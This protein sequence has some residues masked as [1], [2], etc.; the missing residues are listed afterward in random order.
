MNT[1]TVDNFEVE[2]GESH[3]V[4]TALRNGSGGKISR[5]GKLT[6]KPGARVPAEGLTS[7][8]FD[9]YSIISKGDITF[10][11]KD[12][13]SLIKEGSVN[14]VQKDELHWCANETDTEVELVFVL[15][16]N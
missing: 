7:H 9:E 13:A 14:F 4:F 5:L 8:N 12:G 3:S 15:V 6:L 1:I 2:A 16:E 11:T 10:G